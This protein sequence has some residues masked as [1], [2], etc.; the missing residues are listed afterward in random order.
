M[1]L[2]FGSRCSLCSINS[3]GTPGMLV[4]LHVKMSIFSWS[5]LMSVSS[6]LGSKLL[7]T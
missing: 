4:G 6:Y 1:G 7:S 2:T 5:N 3:Y